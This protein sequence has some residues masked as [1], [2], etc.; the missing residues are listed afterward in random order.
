[1]ATTHKNLLASKTAST[2]WIPDSTTS[3]ASHHNPYPH[4]SSR[5]LPTL[6]HIS[7]KTSNGQPSQ[8][9]D[10]ETFPI[11]TFP[12]PNS[13]HSSTYPT[14]PVRP[15]RGSHHSGMTKRRFLFGSHFME[16]QAQ[17]SK[18]SLF[19]TQLHLN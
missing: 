13:G 6:P 15:A 3:L 10:G 8:W 4:C 16:A 5:Q 14:Y 2:L 9:S 19:H 17:F 1:M 18:F 7:N 12:L 11:W